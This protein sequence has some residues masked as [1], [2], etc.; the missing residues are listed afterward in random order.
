MNIGGT[1]GAVTARGILPR[2]LGVDRLDR[3]KVRV[4]V[5]RRTQRR[6]GAD[7]LA[8]VVEVT[9]NDRHVRPPGD[10]IEAALPGLAPA[11]RARGRDD[12]VDRPRVETGPESARGLSVDRVA[13]EHRVIEELQTV[14]CYRPLGVSVV[15]LHP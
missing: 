11:P 13:A 8:R 7:H 1:I 9:G 12:Q 10:V 4:E 14:I 6:R 15:S 3:R 2:H 5:A